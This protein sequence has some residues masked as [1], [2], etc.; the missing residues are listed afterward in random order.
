MTYENLEE[1]VAELKRP[2]SA[3][4]G[5]KTVRAYCHGLAVEVRAVLAG[6]RPRRLGDSLASLGP[7]EGE[8]TEELS[9]RLREARKL[10]GSAEPPV[11]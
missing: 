1:A 10:G 5:E 6:V 3:C 11:L 9:S 2:R 7:W 8:S 4:R